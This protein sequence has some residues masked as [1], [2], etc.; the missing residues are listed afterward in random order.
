MATAAA[1]KS[2]ASSDA[3][4]VVAFYNDQHNPPILTTADFPFA[5]NTMRKRLPAII[6]AL[7]THN[8]A[9]YSAAS[10]PPQRLSHFNSVVVPK[11][12]SLRDAVASGAA[13]PAPVSSNS[14]FA[15]SA[16]ELALWHTLHK[17]YGS[18]GWLQVPTAPF[19]PVRCLARLITFDV[20]VPSNRFRG[21]TL[22]LTFISAC[23][24]RVNTLSAIRLSVVWTLSRR[25][26][27]RSWHVTALG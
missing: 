10:A 8:T 20:F 7:I 22:R 4:S 3:K 11:L 21:S 23:C 17:Q 2:H 18:A 24:K 9:A 19:L 6:D 27:Q 14:D 1:A 25:K 26:R 5:H 15:L 13:L 16:D 12:K